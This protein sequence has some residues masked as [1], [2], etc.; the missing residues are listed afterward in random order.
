MPRTNIVYEQF[1]LLF[2]QYTD[3]VAEWYPQGKYRIRIALTN[4]VRL[5]FRFVSHTDWRLETE[6]SYMTND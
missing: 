6:Q 2:P 5:A 4:G 1:N 3:C